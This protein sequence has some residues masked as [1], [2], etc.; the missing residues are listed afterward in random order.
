MAD[1]PSQLAPNKPHTSQYCSVV[2][3]LVAYATH[4]HPLFIDDSSKVY[5]SLE[6][7]TRH[8]AYA[9]SL[10]PFQRT[11]DGMS[12]HAAMMVQYAGVDKWDK[13]LARSNNLILTRVWKG[14]SN[15]NLEKFISQHRNGYINMCQSAEHVSFQ[16]PNALTRVKSLLKGIQ[17][18][19]LIHI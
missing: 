5:Y 6:E 8:T 18:L 3:D 14:Q 9:A 13:E 19:S 12:A 17:N 15:F 16:L 7:A 2:E 10:K 11:K 4:D 1:L